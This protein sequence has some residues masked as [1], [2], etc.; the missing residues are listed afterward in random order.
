MGRKFIGLKRWTPFN[1][2]LSGLPWLLF[3]V[4]DGFI[5]FCLGKGEFV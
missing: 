1:E 5:K 2:Q 4:Y 3:A